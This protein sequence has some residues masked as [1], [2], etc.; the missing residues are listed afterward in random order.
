MSLKRLAAAG[1]GLAA[2][3]LPQAARA[4]SPFPGAEG[5]YLGILHPLS[6]PGQLLALL[7]IGVMLGWRWRDAFARSWAGFAIAAL[8][9]IVLGQLEIRLDGEEVY[10]LLIA[11]IAATLSALYP[12]G[13]VLAHVILASAGG[14]LIG[15]LS[16][17]DPGPR[18]A[19]IITIAGSFVGANLTLFYVSG[20]VGWV[21]ER[22]T[23]H[24]VEVGL[25]VAAAWIAAVALLMGALAFAGGG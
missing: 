12:K 19:T 16:T 1:L 24:W 11:V 7:A 2:A 20:A 18:A 17:P 21:R 4:H 9:G 5:F 3:L 13:H 25:R 22:F 8:V 15:L 23:Q 10:L 6:T 14:L